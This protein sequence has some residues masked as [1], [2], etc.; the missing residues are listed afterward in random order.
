MASYKYMLAR[1]K[2]VKSIKVDVVDL[3]RKA[4]IEKK[5]DKKSN[6]IYAGAALSALVVS[7]LIISL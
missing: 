7:G 5:R 2:L 6:L 4:K 1:N 3:M